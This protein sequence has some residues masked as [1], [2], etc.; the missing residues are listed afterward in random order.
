MRDESI[1]NTVV[2]LHVQ[3]GWS[4]RRIS[5]E[6]NLS[7][8]RIRRILVS[9]SMLRDTTS[10]DKELVKK[11]RPSK[12]D[13]HKEHIT[14][15]LIKYP[16]ITGQRVH[17]HLKEK[18]YSGEISIVREYLKSV[19]QVGSKTPIKMVETDPGKLAAHDWS[20]YNIAFTSTGQTQQVTFF[21]YILCFSRRQYVSVVENKKQRTL[22]R[23]LIAAFIY[24]DG[25]P[26]EIRSDNQ[27]ACVDSWAPGSPVFNSKYLE[28][29]TWYRFTPKT[30]TPRHPTE[31]LKIE[32]PF[33]YLEQSFLGGRE[34]KDL[35]DLKSQLQLWLKKVNDVRTLGTTKEKPIDGYVQ[36]QPYLQA[37][38]IN[39]F[40]TSLVTHK[41]VN[42]ESCI[43]FE[44]YQYVVPEK[45]MFELCPLRITQNQMIVYSP[46][47][48]QIACH[49]LAE[50]GRKG[51]YVGDHKKSTKKPD[52]PIADVISRLECFSPEMNGYIQ[53]IKQH[54]PGTWRHHLRNML[55][56]KVNYRV[57]D[58]LVAV[59]RAL[60]YK[61]FDSGIIENFLENN[62][63]PRYS[64]KLSFKSK[65]NDYDEQQK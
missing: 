46:C 45:Y 3:K 52:L 28:F 19:R 12:L 30:I 59:R 24:T 17:E 63:E 61:V 57:E 47:G 1:D 27:K 20:D 18:G 33:W 38:P 29:A 34:F 32:R 10:N 35:Q 22:F 62:S 13:Q 40:D 60:R 16:K 64:I 31:N 5:R 8:N 36:E 37:L 14:D 41:V 42:Q 55:A 2:T 65:N 54:K 11:Q 50:K 58:I 21:S 49:P 43:Y 44:G 53:Q 48:E 26:M 39:H 4:V 15:L 7:R 25:V 56:L 51:R 9:N 6:L 23:E